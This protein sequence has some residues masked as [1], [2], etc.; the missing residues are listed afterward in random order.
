MAVDANTIKTT[1]LV[2][3]SI[4]FTEQFSQ[5]LSTL[6]NVLGVTRKQ[7]LSQ[8]S[9]IK[10]Y[11]TEG[12]LVSGDVAEGEIIPLSKITRKE[13]GTQELR[14][15][16]YRKVTTAEAIQKGGFNQAVQTTDQKLLRL[17]QDE[18]KTNWFNFLTTTTGTTSTNG[19][20]FQAAVANAIGQ[21]NV[22]WEGYG[23]QPVAFIN[24]LD[25]YAYLAQAPVSTQTAFG[26]NY[27]ENFMGFSAVILSASVPAGKIYVTAPD[28]IN[29]AYADLH[30]DL[31]GAFNF[32][33]DQTGLIG[34][35]HNELLNAMSYET[36][37]TT[38]SV[39]YPE[40]SAGI[41][42]SDIR[43]ATASK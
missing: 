16:K 31:S 7:A 33:T 13:A 6:L 9:V 2:A 30:G 17:V 8:G 40:I 11:K 26:L 18:V 4:D 32:T 3:Q 22:V 41:I 1:D 20:G 24:P 21:F 15:K 28:N 34:V 42:V 35:A 12:T 38:A 36:V 10:F 19:V 43:T 27:I 14:F 23:V 5:G 39:L 37:V 25:V 29:L